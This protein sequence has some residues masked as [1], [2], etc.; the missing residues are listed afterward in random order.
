MI[1]LR[2]H[3]RWPWWCEVYGFKYRQICEIYSSIDVK[4]RKRIGRKEYRFHECQITGIGLVIVIEIPITGIAEAISI[5]IGL[6]RIGNQVAIVI[7]VQHAIAVRIWVEAL[8]DKSAIEINLNSRE[9]I[10]VGQGAVLSGIDLDT[11]Q[12][13]R[14]IGINI[15]LGCH[16]LAV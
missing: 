10:D 16:S 7:R 1:C 12:Y 6:V 9:I 3:T 15:I 13:S 14:N 11:I 8:V 2:C 5:Y 4:V